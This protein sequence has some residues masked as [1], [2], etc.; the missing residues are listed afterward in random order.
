MAKHLD[1]LVVKEQ[2]GFYW[3]ETADGNV[4]MCTLRGRLKEEARK[5]DIA[6]IGDRVKFSK[7]EREA[8]AYWDSQTK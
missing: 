5:S 4:Y 6:A 1:G 2:S 3:V 8:E 7:M